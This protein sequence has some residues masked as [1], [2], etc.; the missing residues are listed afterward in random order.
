MINE[1]EIVSFLNGKG[2]G[3]LANQICK[4]SQTGNSMSMWFFNSDDMDEK[5]LAGLEHFLKNEL[6]RNFRTM[7]GDTVMC[8]HFT[9]QE[10]RDIHAATDYYSQ[11][12]KQDAP[13]GD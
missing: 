5:L 1:S 3:I 10:E 12:I 4:A 7:Y 8:N 2:Y 11:I 9:E 6:G 13:N